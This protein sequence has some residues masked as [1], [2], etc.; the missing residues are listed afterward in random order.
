ME[1]EKIKENC[2][3]ELAEANFSGFAQGYYFQDIIG[4]CISMG[5]TDGEWKLLNC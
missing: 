3:L 5:L 4:L 1:K 2:M